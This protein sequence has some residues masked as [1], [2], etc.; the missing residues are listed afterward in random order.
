[1][2]GII[3]TAFGT[4]GVTTIGTTFM[5]KIIILLSEGLTSVNMFSVDIRR[6]EF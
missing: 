2:S 4:S 6:M 1:M 5:T 3:D